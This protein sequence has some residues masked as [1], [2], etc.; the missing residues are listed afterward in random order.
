MRDSPAAFRAH[1]RRLGE[2]RYVYAVLARRSRG[3]S[4]GVNLNPDKICNW[5]CVYCQV[6]RTTPPDVRVVDLARLGAE[7]GTTLAAARAGTLFDEP[8][9]AT[10]PPGLRR[11][12]DIAFAGDGEPTSY[13]RFDDAIATAIEV[14]R[15]TGWTDLP[16]VVLTNATL[17]DRPA[18]RR[19][20]DLLAADGGEIWAKLDAGTETYFRLVDR[21]H[22]ALERCVRLITEEARRR[23]LVIQSLFALIDGEPPSAAEIDAYIERLRQILDAGGLVRLVQVTTL[24]RPPALPTVAMLDGGT[25][26]AL[27]ARVRA[28]LPGLAVETYDGVPAPL[29]PS[30]PRRERSSCRSLR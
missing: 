4:V 11:L 2:N 14:K 23:P 9:F 15:E 8:R 5:D 3:V 27:A 28:A 24:A 21:P 10:A 22:H 30:G 26:D 19:G 29:E 6:D 17:L 12:A 13:P 20:L 16:I 18:V 7:L 25:L 1:G